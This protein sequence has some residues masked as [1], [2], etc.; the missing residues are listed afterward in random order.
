MNSNTLGYTSSLS[1]SAIGRHGRRYRELLPFLP[2][3]G[4]ITEKWH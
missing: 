4:R 2:K 3:F 1:T